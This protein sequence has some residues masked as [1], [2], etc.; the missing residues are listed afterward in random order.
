MVIAPPRISRNARVAII[1]PAKVI[2]YDKIIAAKKV[3]ETWGLQ[4]ILSD[5]IDSRY[6]QFAG[7]DEMRTAAFQNLLD[8]PSIECIFCA[9]GGYGTTRIIDNLDFAGFSSAP[10]WIIGYSDITVILNQLYNLGY[11]G[12]HGPMPLNFGNEGTGESLERLRNFLQQGILADLEWEGDKQNISGRSNGLLLGGNLTMIVNT[13]GTRSEIDTN[14]TILILEDVDEQLY[15]I[16]RM[17]V[18]LKRAGKLKNLR[19]LIAGHFTSIKDEDTFGESIEEILLNHVSQYGY[20]VCFNAPIGHE[21]PNHPVPLGLSY[22]LY[23]GKKGC[24]LSLK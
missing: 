10:K 18:Q 12:I 17:V 20:P 24:R 5:N 7:D 11:S 22:H 13:L 23:V 14:N 19:A 2:D 6:H 15:K 9:R 21:M 16:D 8:D 1:P 3:L 4:V